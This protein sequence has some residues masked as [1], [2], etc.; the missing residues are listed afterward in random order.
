MEPPLK[1]RILLLIAVI[2]IQA[3]YTPT[4]LLMKGGIE[5]KLPWDIFPLQVGWI[6]PYVAC[7]PLWAFALGWLVLK[8]DEVR[9][10][11]AIAGLFF[12]CSLG[13]SVFLLFPTY[14]VHPDIPG[15]DVLSKLLLSLTV[16]GGDYDA[17]PSAHIYVTTILALFYS[18]WYP[19]QKWIWMFIVVM[20]SLSTLFTKQ[21]YIL[22]VLTGYITGWLGY[23]FGLWWN[24]LTLKRMRPA[25]T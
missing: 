5:P 23:R 20:V 25:H 13:V 17:L 19:K 21:H 6:I 4:S 14:V 18:H 7:Y 8:M 22:D 16:A 24:S 2:V 10:R 9:F 12:A 11:K 3:I 1:K 15:K